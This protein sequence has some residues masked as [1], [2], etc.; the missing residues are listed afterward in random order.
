M[1]KGRTLIATIALLSLCFVLIIGFHLLKEQAK[2]FEF[3]EIGALLFGIAI[4]FIITFI[5]NCLVIVLKKLSANEGHYTYTD[6]YTSNAQKLVW[7]QF[8]NTGVVIF[9]INYYNKNIGDVG[10]L[11]DDVCYILAFNAVVNPM[12]NFFNPWYCLKWC[13]RRSLRKIVKRNPG[14]HTI[15]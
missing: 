7:A 1:A 3:S 2:S 13:K 8:F 15:S 4:S 5:N 11:I 12:I 10:G 6:F 9:I 14:G